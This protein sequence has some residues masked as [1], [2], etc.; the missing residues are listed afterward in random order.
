MTSAAYARDEVWNPLIPSDRK[1]EALSVVPPPYTQMSAMT[2][3][4]ETNAN[5]NVSM[6]RPLPPRLTKE[7]VWG[8]RDDWGDGAKEWGRGA[9]AYE[10]KGS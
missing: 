4:S 6:K 3:H 7:H 1:W 5:E 10:K 8:V 9:K 2:S